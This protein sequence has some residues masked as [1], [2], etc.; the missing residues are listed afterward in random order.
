L[1]V[2]PITPLA[3]PP[4]V[5]TPP[6]FIT[7][8]THP[9]DVEGFW[10]LSWLENNA[11]YLTIPGSIAAGATGNLLSPGNINLI[12]EVSDHYAD[13]KTEKTTK[14]Q[15]DA[16]RKKALDQLKK[17]IG[18][19]EKLLFGNHTSHQSI[20]IARRGAIPATA[21]ITRHAE[22]LKRLGAMSKHGGIVLAG[23]GLTA[24]CMQIASTTDTKEKNEI[25]VETITSTA[26][27]GAL[28]YGVAIFLISNP[29]GWGTAIVLAV[30]SVAASYLAGKI[31][32]GA[33]DTHGKIDFVVGTG[34]NRICR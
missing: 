23:V 33:Y 15:Y 14:G 4:A 7:Q 8:P 27:G 12:N 30:G 1:G 31:A 29:I 10:A 20:R 18:P 6:A 17:N 16:R 11:N 9:G 13:Y 32:R 21:H 26:V 34:V 25:L 24:A 2:L 19:M 28:G 5:H 3:K 22:R